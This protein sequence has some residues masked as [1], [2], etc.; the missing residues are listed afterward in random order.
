[1]PPPPKSAKPPETVRI[2]FWREGRISNFQENIFLI[3]ENLFSGGACVDAGATA[4]IDCPAMSRASLVAAVLVAAL[5]GFV[6][7][8]LSIPGEPPPPRVSREPVPGD[9]TAASVHAAL[10][11]PD[12]LERAAALGR[13][14][15]ALGPESLEPVRTAFDAVVLE[16]SDYEVQLF[17]LWW[18]RFDP[19]AAAAWALGSHLGRHPSAVAAAVRAWAQQDPQ[20]A[21]DWVLG[22]VGTPYLRNPAL[23][24]LVWGWDESGQPGL[25][26]FVA[27]IG[28]IV[29]QQSTLAMLTRRR[30]LRDG[31]EA[32]F[33]WADALP[34]DARGDSRRLKLN[35]FR[36]IGAKLAEI[37]PPAA[38][39]WAEQVGEGEYGDGLYRR[40][41]WSWV[42]IDG[43]AAMAWLRG[44]PPGPRRREAVDEG[45]RRWSTLDQPAAMAWIAAQPPEP[46]QA[47]ARF[48]QATNT[49]GRDPVEGMRLAAAIPDD[50]L[51]SRAQYLILRGW[52]NR[53]PEEANAWIA[54]HDLPETLLE[55]LERFPGRRQP[56]DPPRSHDRAR[57]SAAQPGHA[58]G[59]RAE[60]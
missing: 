23:V 43:P 24:A 19:P 55:K 3:L 30:L 8:R 44:L 28:D 47:P 4:Q 22:N 2:G 39:A 17:V 25:W 16:G 50:E 13:A 15:D 14:L 11:T 58:T 53:E 36:R 10:M 29:E 52:R 56:G 21:R 18:A 51:R 42:R 46:W 31:P 1:M 35:T 54:A 41:A 33:R 38:A 60:R 32:T 45:F 12:P 34:D 57:G 59:T 49:G 37:D 9:P 40:V 20:A 26:D 6:T 5:V 48:W 7:G 27:E